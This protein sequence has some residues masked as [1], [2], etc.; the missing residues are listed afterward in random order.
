MHITQRSNHGSFWIVFE[1]TLKQENH[2]IIVWSSSLQKFRFQN[3]FCPRETE[4]PTFSN[5][6]G[7]KNVFE[8][9]QKGLVS[10]GRPHQNCANCLHAGLYSN[11]DCC[12]KVCITMYWIMPLKCAFHPF[13]HIFLCSGLICQYVLGLKVTNHSQTNQ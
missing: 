12:E 1:K 9:L 13:A 6:S 4:W 5:S 10:D 8:K 2:M 3:V 7:L 11:A